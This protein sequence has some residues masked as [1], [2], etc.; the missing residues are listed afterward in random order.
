MYD[1]T[2]A[3][4]IATLYPELPL[5]N[6]G[7]VNAKTD[8][9]SLNLNWSEKD[10][11]EFS[12]T[13]HVHRLHPYLGKFIPQLVEIFLRKFKPKLV[14]DPFSG[15]GTTVVEANTLGISS[16]G[17]DVSA[18]NILISKVK[19]D[20][21]DG[22]ELTKEVRDIIAKLRNYRKN[23]IV[24]DDD[25]FKLFESGPLYVTE[26]EYINSWFGTQARSDL[27]FYLDQIKN[28]RY[29][30]VLKLILSRSARSARLVKHF[31]LDFPKKPQMEPY[32]C[33][34][35]SRICQP[36]Q[37][38]FKFLDRY[39]IDTL[40][41]IMAFSKIRTKANVKLIHGDL[42]AIELPSGIDLVFTSPPYIGLI[43]YHEQHRYAYELLGIPMHQSNEIGPAKGGQ[44]EAARKLYIEGINAVLAH[45][46]KSMT[47]KGKM[48][49]IVNDK[50]KLYDPKA[51][52][53]EEVGRVERHV[54]RRT[55]NAKLRFTRAS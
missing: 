8:L 27:L 32:D 50:F 41:R 2:I 31:D 6:F 40:G 45:T 20:S 12:R 38:A 43:D 24:A 4:K 15:S 35:H 48:I 5:T 39:S 34:K 16:I 30:D 3:T 33:Y 11:P 44:S 13:K 47:K 53:F 17:T 25:G 55:D 14:Y 21:Y 29:Q 10:L 49:I 23:T 19:T 28:Y 52:G 54:N 9:S 46:R 36:T 42:R 18:F 37:E 26:N 1:N 51:V 7:S 22:S